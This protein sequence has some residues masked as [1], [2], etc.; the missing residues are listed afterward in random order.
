[1]WEIQE[2]EEDQYYRL[3]SFEIPR[4][5]KGQEKKQD[6]YK[7]DRKLQRGQYRERERERERERDKRKAKAFE[8]KQQNTNSKTPTEQQRTEDSVER[9][10]G[11]SMQSE[12][13]LSFSNLEINSEKET[14]I[15]S[16]TAS[17]TNSER[18]K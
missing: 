18:R 13:R 14:E 7:R 15:E 6:E 1:M 12:A 10:P 4:K 8:N 3:L 17:T 16:R 2:G 9:R 11:K 5:K